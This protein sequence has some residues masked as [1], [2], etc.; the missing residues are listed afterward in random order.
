MDSQTTWEFSLRSFLSNRLFVF[1]LW[2]LFAHF[3]RFCRAEIK[4]YIM[5]VIIG[6]AFYKLQNTLQICYHYCWQYS[7][8]FSLIALYLNNKLRNNSTKSTSEKRIQLFFV[9]NSCISPELS[10]FFFIILLNSLLNFSLETFAIA[11]IC[12]VLMLGHS[13][14]G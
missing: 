9:Y 3:A 8:T 4:W 14:N 10:C 11:G 13:R 2:M 7:E 6:K 12:V 5:R 1:W